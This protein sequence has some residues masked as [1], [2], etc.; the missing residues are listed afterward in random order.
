MSFSLLGSSY[1]PNGALSRD[2][3][4]EDQDDLWKWPDARQS[5]SSSRVMDVILLTE[6]LPQEP[7]FEGPW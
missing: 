3:D 6:N 7:D 2:P 1:G 4:F 5:S